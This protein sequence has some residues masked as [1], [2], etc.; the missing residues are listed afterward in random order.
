M[1]ELK[2]DKI[3]NLWKEF[4]EW[5]EKAGND[6]Y[7][8][9]WHTDLSPEEITPEMYRERME[10]FIAVQRGCDGY[11]ES[12]DG[13]IELFIRN[14]K[15]EVRNQNAW[16]EDYYNILSPLL[17]EAQEK[18][19]Y[20]YEFNT[21]LRKLNSKVEDLE[22]DVERHAARNV[23]NKIV[24]ELQSKYD[25]QTPKDTSPISITGPIYDNDDAPTYYIAINDTVIETTDPEVVK[26]YRKEYENR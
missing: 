10:R 25:Y 11:P 14:F 24:D 19:D 9:F 4:E 16:D 17:K 2:N 20:R 18:C 13:C 8:L 21:A 6:L 15:K 12:I 26:K 22:K 7:F 1:A 3:E 5:R 23:Y